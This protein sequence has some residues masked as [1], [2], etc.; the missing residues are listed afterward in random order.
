[1]K[2]LN[3]LNVFPDELLV[4]IRKYISEG[5]LYIPGTDTRKEWGE[6]FWSKI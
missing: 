5:F 4:E 2:Y 1:M 3:A 6:H